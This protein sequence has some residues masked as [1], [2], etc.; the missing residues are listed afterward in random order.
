MNKKIILLSLLLLVVSLIGSQI[1]VADIVHPN[2]ICMKDADGDGY[3]GYYYASPGTN[4]DWFRICPGCGTAASTNSVS[5]YSAQQGSVTA[6]NCYAG[7]DAIIGLSGAALLVCGATWI[8]D[9]SSSLSITGPIDFEIDCRDTPLSLT[10]HEHSALTDLVTGGASQ[11]GTGTTGG[12]STT[13]S[14]QYYI[15]PAV[16]ETFEKGRSDAVDYNCD[17]N[18]WYDTWCAPDYDGDG[19]GVAG[20]G[21][22][23]SLRYS[24]DY[25]G[26]PVLG[27]LENHD[28]LAVCNNRE[29]CSASYD[30]NTE[31]YDFL[32]YQLFTGNEPGIPFDS[33]DDP[34]DSQADCEAV[35]YIWQ[36]VPTTGFCAGTLICGTLSTS[37]ST[38]QCDSNSYC[39]ES[40]QCTGTYDCDDFSWWGQS[41][42]EAQPNCKWN[43]AGDTC[44]MYY[45]GFAGSGPQECSWSAF[46]GQNGC[47]AGVPGCQ[48][49]EICVANAGTTCSSISSQSSCTYSSAPGCSWQTQNA[50]GVCGGTVACETYD[51]SSC[52]TSK[53]CTQFANGYCKGTFTCSGLSADL[54]ETVTGCDLS[55]TGTCV[56]DESELFVARVDTEDSFGGTS[57]YF[58]HY[59]HIFLCEDYFLDDT[60]G[61]MTG[62]PSTCTSSSANKCVGAPSC[63]PIP[64]YDC[65]DYTGCNYDYVNELPGSTCTGQ[66]SCSAYSYSSCPTSLGCQTTGSCQVDSTFDCGN[67]EVAGNAPGYCADGCSGTGYSL[68]CVANQ[69]GGRCEDYWGNTLYP[70]KTCVNPT[71]L[72]TVCSAH[73]DPTSCNAD[74]RCN[75]VGAGCQNTASAT[76]TQFTTSTSCSS[77]SCTWVASGDYLCQKETQYVPSVI[78]PRIDCDDT[79]RREGGCFCLRDDDHDGFFVL[80]SELTY[81]QPTCP[82]G[83]YQYSGELPVQPPAAAPSWVDPAWDCDDNNSLLTYRCCNSIEYPSFLASTVSV[84][85]NS[86][87]DYVKGFENY[88]NKYVMA[89]CSQP[90]S[91]VDRF[92]V[93]SL[94]LIGNFD[95]FCVSP[96]TLSTNYVP[97]QNDTEIVCSPTNLPTYTNYNTNG[98]WIDL[99]ENSTVCEAANSSFKWAKAGTTQIFG[100]YVYVIG[101]SVPAYT[102]TNNLGNQITGAVTATWPSTPSYYNV[103]NYECCGDDAG[104]VAV[105]AGCGGTTTDPLCCPNDQTY[106]NF[107][108]E[109]IPESQCPD[110]QRAPPVFT[111]VDDVDQWFIWQDYL[112]TNGQGYCCNDTT[113]MTNYPLCELVDDGVDVEEGCFVTDSTLQPI[114]TPTPNKKWCLE[115]APGEDD[116]YCLIDRANVSVSSICAHGRACNETIEPV[117]LSTTDSFVNCTTYTKE[118]DM[119]KVY[120]LQPG[121]TEANVTGCTPDYQDIL[122]GLG[123]NCHAVCNLTAP[124]GGQS[125]TVPNPE[126]SCVEAC[127]NYLS[128][129]PIPIYRDPACVFDAGCAPNESTVETV[130]GKITITSASVCTSTCVGGNCPSL[131]MK[132]ELECVDTTNCLNLIGADPLTCVLPENIQKEK[133]EVLLSSGN[134]VYCQDPKAGIVGQQQVF[135]DYW[136]PDPSIYDYNLDGYCEKTTAVCDQGFGNNLQYGCNTPLT[137]GN[138]TW[139]LYNSECFGASVLTPPPTGTY[140]VACCLHTTFSNYH[141]YQ[142]D[143]VVTGINHVKVY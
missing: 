102:P 3:A 99:D 103:V 114:T 22:A 127:E 46:N 74:V 29:I 133:Y 38:S 28:P 107:E 122:Y 138:D 64:D 60:S 91:C 132:G 43:S 44:Y 76:C 11:R 23:V 134:K 116:P 119:H 62:K 135:G 73:T 57:P 16:T 47:A 41:L 35:G 45:F 115:Q 10:A 9:S 142:D 92:N 126:T 39:H 129:V 98:S 58:N 52:P 24:T 59:D 65:N 100:E 4:S 95:A 80:D 30:C 17:G 105:T 111:A 53:G 15:N 101:G 130:D 94:P 49:N 113:N 85:I 31:Y 68:G 128:A 79:N 40:E 5:L 97:T 69:T 33:Y 104:E 93:S 6:P 108:G 106:V 34:L 81:D 14:R 27:N 109:C 63:S 7:A 118:T 66:F 125:W 20:E 78:Q 18:Y 42:C 140:D 77:H 84:P 36:N 48:A 55:S 8:Q 32:D 141:V 139:G 120:K 110:I 82:T 67:Y 143:P 88:V 75:F 96:G 1:V 117:T 136:C 121:C 124:L 26:S 86:T 123:M 50:A 71:N 37:G 56:Y 19:F 72:A 112:T 61:C 137:P 13:C 87:N 12:S 2:F 131:Q 90:N 83:T 54:C 70:E 25:Y 89:C 51:Y 21:F